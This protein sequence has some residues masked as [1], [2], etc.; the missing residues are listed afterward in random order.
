MAALITGASGGIGCY[1]AKTL[2]EMGFEVIL[3]ARSVDKLEALAK[4]LPNKAE[5][6][7][8]DLS[9]PEEC[10]GL[11]EKLK[12]RKIEVLINNAGFGEF[13][14]FADGDLD[15]QLNMIDLNVKAVHILT[16]LFLKDFKEKGYGY[17]LNV[18]SLAAFLPGPMMASYYA[19]KA[20]VYRLTMA[21]REE[22]R[23][24]GSPVYAGV[25]CPGPVSTG[26]N[27]RAG[28]RFATKGIDPEYCAKYAVEKMFEE[29]AVIIPGRAEKLLP[30]LTKLSP[31]NW[32]MF[33]CGEF[34]KKKGQGVDK[35][36]EL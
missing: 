2:S 3:A 20:Y 30:L 8:A 14:S 17:I 21:I 9:K 24:E 15:T 25:L 13:A 6:F 1:M 29:K 36:G 23:R 35:N 28:V 12:G 11:Y 19:G 5:V 18:A 32:Q 27:K 22:L 10:K 33:F 16:K 4:T 31:V 26:F 7:G 34:Q